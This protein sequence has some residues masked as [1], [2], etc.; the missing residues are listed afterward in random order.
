MELKQLFHT[1]FSSTIS[2]LLIWSSQLKA[3]PK[4]I[5]IEGKTIT[6]PQDHYAQMRAVLQQKVV[7]VT[8]SSW[9]IALLGCYAAGA[10]VLKRLPGIEAVISRPTIAHLPCHFFRTTSSEKGYIR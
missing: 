1:I 4:A 9:R 6:G 5:S 8:G 10:A 7:K 3:I 2:V